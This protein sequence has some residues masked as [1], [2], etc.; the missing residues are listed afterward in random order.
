MYTILL[1]DDE[2]PAL[3]FLQAIIEKYTP[4][5]TVAQSC[6]SGEAA[7]LYL[8]ENKVDLLLTDIS[9]PG[10]DGIALSMQARTV[11][12]DI[13]IVIISGYAEFEYAKGAIHAG[14]EEYML[15]PVGIPQMTEILSK[16]KDK[17]DDEYTAKEP[18]LLS[19]LL[20]GQP[21]DKALATRLYGEGTYFF[22]LIRWGNLYYSQGDLH[23]TSIIPIVDM[24]FF[25]LYGRD[26]DEQILFMKA[27][28]PSTDFQSAVKV[29]IAQRKCATWT[30]VFARSENAFTALPDFFHRASQL[31]ERT[32]VIGRRQFVFLSANTPNVE[33]PHVPSSTLKKLELF[34]HDGNMKMVKDIFISLAVDWEKRQ[35][36][37][38]YATTIVQQLIHLVLAARPSLGTQ[39]DMIIRSSNE[40]LR[41]AA[42]Y[43]DLMA[44]LYSILF[45]DSAFMDKKLTAHDLYNYAVRYIQ[46][47][48]AEPI[49]IWH[50]CSEIGISQTYLSRLFRKYG[51]TSFNVYLTKCRMDNAMALIR[52][53]PDMPLRNVAECVGYEDYA[54]FSKVFHQIVGC[55]PS[56]WAAE[57]TE[58]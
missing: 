14:V 52:E 10:M 17:L 12:P 45:D 58:K 28:R 31:M 21:Y 11:C 56:Q 29:Y 4:G 50:V 18:S 34:I 37:Q 30:I 24:P 9:M 44:G 16:I 19:S 43:G 20:S 15:K 3:R 55:A 47:K 40:L 27:D 7:L 22:A 26:E 23:V 13:H 41:Y 51:D 53:H 48:Y 5:F 42:S 46:E 2:M 6:S 33:T 32:V 39:Q 38:L 35:T 54:Y 49:S 8:K 36:A 57:V 25:A 1:V